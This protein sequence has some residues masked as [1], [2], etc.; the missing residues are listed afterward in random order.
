MRPLIVNEMIM[1]EILENLSYFKKFAT[2]KYD[3][4][5]KVEE[6]IGYVNCES[7]CSL[8]LERCW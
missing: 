8:K 3:L 5:N 1:N 6:C 4:K 7:M 2:L